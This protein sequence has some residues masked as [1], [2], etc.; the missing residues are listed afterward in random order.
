MGT[1]SAMD[2]LQL[3]KEI[4]S[5][6][7]AKGKRSFRRGRITKIKT[8]LEVIQTYPLRDVKQ[9]ELY[10]LKQDLQREC[11]LHIALQNRF[12]SL[13]ELK[14]ATEEELYDEACQGEEVKD[15]HRHLQQ[16]MQEFIEQHQHY[17]E[18]LTIEAE[19]ELLSNITDITT[20]AFEEAY[21]KL[22]TR[23]STFQ[24]DT[25]EYKDDDQIS[26][27][28]QHFKNDITKYIKVLSEAQ[29]NEKKKVD[30]E[31]ST[32]PI[33]VTV[34][35]REHMK[36][37]IELPSFSGR[38]IYWRAFYDLF[39]STI[40][41]RGKHLNDKEKRCLLIKAMKSDE[42]KDIV[43]VHSQ[44][45]DGYDNAIKALVNNYGSPKIIYPHHIRSLIAREKYTYDRESLRRMRQ[46]FLLNYEAMKTI[47]AATLSQFLAALAFE[48]FDTRLKDEW[49]K[50][51]ASIK[52][53]P[54]LEQMFEFFEPLEYNMAKVETTPTTHLSQK[55]STTSGKKM[56]PSSKATT[57]FSK[58]TP[59][60]CLLC[61]DQQHSLAKCSV[62]LSYDVPH[63][64]K[65]V[66]DNRRCTNCLHHS[67][68]H[69]QCT[70]TFSCRH[71]HGRH[72]SLLHR[73]AN[74]N[75]E[76][77]TTKTINLLGTSASVVDATE[78]VATSVAPPTIAFLNTA[79]VKAVNG[80][81]HRPA[82]AALDTGA[83]SSLITEGLT[84]HLKL[85][86]YPQRSII[87]GAYGGGTSR[88]YV[89]ATLQS[90]SDANQTLTLRLSVVP[91]LP[92]AHPPKRQEDI[93][94]EQYIKDLTLADP[95]FGGPLDVL[96]GSLDCC[97]CILGIF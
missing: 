36:F 3:V 8:R 81:R 17:Q 87:E 95:D 20:K 12:E 50:H 59:S 4:N 83:A 62:F 44:G 63:R 79:V 31:S 27:L 7:S 77:E 47:K 57:T 19:F 97:R 49:T 65:Y 26:P 66:K 56:N 94:N 68:T 90:S 24:H 30:G 64:Q 55:T 39:S 13:L 21:A 34:P 15:Q 22:S 84:S 96:I 92:A 40:N 38:P 69:R 75:T 37:D 91:K 60:K 32:T 85:K 29:A 6:D 48:D 88:H 52:D 93:L 67:H 1:I 42:A 43:L 2:D 54:T 46:R 23:V 28:R 11:D 18:A 14:E 45:E 74:A 10:N 9:K 82:R 61:N 86:R 73:D 41:T 76:S 16:Q 5:L 35:V 80:S 53:L 71:C 89:Q 51:T 58:T 25:L 70:S 33:P 72:H 78:K